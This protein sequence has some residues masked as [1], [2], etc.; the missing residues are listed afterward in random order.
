MRRIGGR[1]DLDLSVSGQ[2]QA[3][4]L[5]AHFNSSGLCFS[6]I[7][8]APLKR[9]MQTAK[10]IQSFGAQRCEIVCETDLIEIDYGP[11]E[12]KPEE[13]V[14]ARIG[15]QALLRW[16]IDS[17]PPADWNVTPGKLVKMWAAFFE[18][19]RTHDESGP[20]LAVTSN[21]IARF[22]LDAATI[23]QSDFPR[24]LRT[25][26]YG[27]ISLAGAS[28]LVEEWDRRP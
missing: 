27:R 23:T 10:A 15:R 3:K 9:A 13:E 8:S 6:Q 26:A 17:I 24:K 19:L 25:G 20:F 12:N 7:F 11:D 4:L 1:T 16:D 2:K 18:K 14:V 21:G 22:A 28:V 5:G